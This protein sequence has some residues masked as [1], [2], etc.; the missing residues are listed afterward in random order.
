MFAYD[1]THGEQSAVSP[2]C[3]VM[4]GEVS[5][6]IV[7]HSWA[8]AVHTITHID[9][10]THTHTPHC[11]SVHILKRDL[12]KILAV[13]Q[14]TSSAKLMYTNARDVFIASSSSRLE[15]HKSLGKQCLNDA[16][17]FSPVDQ[18]CVGELIFI[19]GFA[20]RISLIRPR[21]RPQSCT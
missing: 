6:F 17:L 21:C 13:V 20:K 11:F 16:L 5:I 9:A 15:L 7:P 2:R 3:S 1:S 18:W 14:M 10:Y 19:D 12:N 4:V 8:M